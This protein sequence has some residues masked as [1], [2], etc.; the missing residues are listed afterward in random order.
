MRIRI[1][2]WH[3]R[4]KTPEKGLKLLQQFPG[5]EAIIVTNDGKVVMTS[6]LEGKIELS[7]EL[8]KK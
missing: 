8:E 5:N 3:S 1:P 4:W 7:S 2:F 6:G